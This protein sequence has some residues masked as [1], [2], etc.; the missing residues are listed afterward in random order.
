LAAVLYGGDGGADGSGS[1]ARQRN[2]PDGLDGP[3]EVSHEF[4]A[5]YG[6]QVWI[7]I[8]AAD[9]APRSVTIRWGPWERRLVHQSDGPVSYW[10][11]KDPPKPGDE[12]VPTTVR[13]EP[14]A[15]VDFAQGTPPVGAID[16]SNDWDHAAEAP[17][18][19]AAD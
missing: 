3:V 5:S 4:P 1:A 16:A 12:N 9:D 10:F 11:T 6:G 2:E 18:E 19:A 14:R 13:I 15:E 17:D 7:T 8:S